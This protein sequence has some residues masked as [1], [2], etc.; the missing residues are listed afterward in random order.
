M[1]SNNFIYQ[2]VPQR[3]L[4]QSLSYTGMSQALDELLLIPGNIGMLFDILLAEKV[5]A[6]LALSFVPLGGPYMF[7]AKLPALLGEYST[8][9]PDE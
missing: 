8:G 5:D 6:I 2:I 9:V 3:S 1:M 4:D 7:N